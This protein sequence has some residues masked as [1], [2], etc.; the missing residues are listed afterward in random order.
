MFLVFMHF[1]FRVL[2]CLCSFVTSTPE[3]QH[4]QSCQ[5]GCTESLF[6]GQPVTA[7]CPD[8]N[9]DPNQ[10]LKLRLRLSLGRRLKGETKLYTLLHTKNTTCNFCAQNRGTNMVFVYHPCAWIHIHGISCTYIHP[11]ATTIDKVR[12]DATLSTIRHPS[13]SR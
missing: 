11:A 3:V 2:L 4:G 1:L 6:S 9:T 7:R 5:I 8:T 12:A 13:P 10:K